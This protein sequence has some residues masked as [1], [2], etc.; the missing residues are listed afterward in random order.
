MSTSGTPG[1]AMMSLT[2]SVK[3]VGEILATETL[4]LEPDLNASQTAYYPLG[5]FWRL[6]GCTH[7]LFCYLFSGVN[8]TITYRPAVRTANRFDLPSAW[9]DLDSGSSNATSDGPVNGGAL[10][11]SQP[12]PV[13]F[14]GQAG[15][16]ITATGRG[17]LKIWVVGRF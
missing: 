15:L 13:E 9:T 4:E 3:D 7:L 17:T 1:E 16:K 14:Y 10:S 6:Q 2:A 11:I 8:G 5:R 12:S